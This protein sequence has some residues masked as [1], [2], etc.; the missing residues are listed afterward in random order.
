MAEDH[1]QRIVQLVRHASQQGPH[2][3]QLLSLDPPGLCDFERLV[4]FGHLLVKSGVLQAHG[5]V[6]GERLE[7]FEV[8]LAP[9]LRI[10]AVKEHEEAHEKLAEMNGDDEALLGPSWNRREE[11]ATLQTPCPS[12]DGSG[13][14][15]VGR[16][17][18]AFE[19]F[20]T[21][22]SVRLARA[23]RNVE[24]AALGTAHFSRDIHRHLC[25]RPRVEDRGEDLSR[26]V[27]REEIE[28]LR[29]EARLHR[30]GFAHPPQVLSSVIR[31][32]RTCAEVHRL[33]RATGAERAAPSCS[34][35]SATITRVHR[36]FIFSTT[37]SH[38][39]KDRGAPCPATR[40][41]NSRRH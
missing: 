29:V 37:S 17:R 21:G 19:G 27:E 3:G 5:D 24:C 12:G 18:S 8:V 31:Y 13:A 16:E 32:S 38:S 39:T 30:I 28:D 9:R 10:H 40:A 2:R 22:K 11:G 1:G 6:R 33:G 25:Q 7:N 23:A 26:L 41:P 15:E 4:L 34:S 20:D 36:A 14:P 35:R